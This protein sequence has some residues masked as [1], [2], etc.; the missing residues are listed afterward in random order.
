M[1]SKVVLAPSVKGLTCLLKLCGNYCSEFD[2][3]LNPGKSK[4]MYFGRPVSVSYEVQLDGKTIKWTN[5]CLYLGVLL[6]TS[7][8]FNCAITERVKKFYRC[9]NSILRIDGQ[10]SDT[11]MLRLLETH[12]IPILTYAIEV[13]HVT[14]RDERRQLRVAYNSIFRR[15]FCYRRSESVTT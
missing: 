1:T 13:I 8:V 11:V 15:I 12:C 7:K 10:S 14:N 6:S 2:I 3:G 5:E 9:A 4:L